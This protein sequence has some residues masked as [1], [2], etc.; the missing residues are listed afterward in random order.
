M[1]QQ[2]NYA[3][4][5]LLAAR[6]QGFA[7]ALH[8]QTADAI[9]AGAHNAT[10]RALL[11]ESLTH[12]RALERQNAQ[13]NSIAEDFDRFGFDIWTQVDGE[14]SGN[15][16]RRR[17]LWALI[18]WRNAITHDDIG[19]KLARGALEPLAISLVTCR[20]WRSALNVLA[21]SLDK[22]TA[23]RCQTLGLPRPW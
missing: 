15:D 13:P 22:V 7:R 2:L 10:Y 6:F 12:N 18:T 1:T 23:D 14:R 3:Y 17:K 20:S 11:R 19:T 5:T 21:A 4:T 16:Q 8:T 9:A